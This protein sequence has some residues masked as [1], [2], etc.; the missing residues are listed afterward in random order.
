M[1][2]KAPKIFIAGIYA[3]DLVFTGRRMPAPGETVPASG[4]MRGHGGK[5]SNQAI[6]AARAGGDVSFF[7]FVGD[8]LFGREAIESWR[9]EGIHNKAVVIKGEATGA[10][11]IF[12]NADTGGN[13]I[14][15]FPGA[16]RLMKSGD[17]DR[18]EADIAAS[19][20]FV[21]QL[22][23]PVEV[24]YRG[25]ELA[26]K[27]RV[28]T[29]LNP[30]PAVSLPDDIF[31]FCDYILPNESESSLLTGLPVETPEQAQAAA[32]VLLSKGVRNVIVTLGEKGALFCDKN[33]S[34]LVG[35]VNAG[36][37]VD[38]TGAGDGFTAGFAVGLGHGLTT[39]AAM[40]FATALAGI[41]VTRRG[42]APSMPTRTEIE[43]VLGKNSN[44]HH[45]QM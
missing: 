13:A 28:A 10:A 8:D 16:S 38:T 35:P 34:F 40:E 17:M 33:E 29:I 26:H 25:L 4:F 7:T 19:D 12:V 41:S 23:Q 6:A 31:A 39:R 9:I 36:K 43:A 18:V 42:A 32:R 15:V 11:G 14:T 27:H 24:A 20:V 3:M 2:A 30:A 21:V 37:C 22:E 5:G 44:A 45:S 1:A